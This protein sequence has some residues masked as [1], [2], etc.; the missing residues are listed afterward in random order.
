MQQPL[1]IALIPCLFLTSCAS[2]L[3]KS[4]YPVAITS[5][6]S[7]AKFTV[8]NDTGVVV[9][10]G[11]TP[12]TVTL[13]ASAGYLKAA[14]YT[15]EFSRKGNSSQSIQINAKVDGWYFGNLLLGG[16]IGMVVVD[17]LTGAMWKLDDTVNANFKTLA[18]LDNGH[19]RQ[20]QFVDRS[21][22]HG[23]TEKHLVALR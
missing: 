17:P 19:G 11:T 18:T 6:P 12:S 3:S 4:Q 8:T 21:S 20:L 16:L 22:I 7:G 14:S 2:I 23:E 10:Q 1:A 5:S 13:P 15:V 9:H